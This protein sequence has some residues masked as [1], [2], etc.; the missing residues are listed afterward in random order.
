[1]TPDPQ[2]KKE[3]KMTGVERIAAERER[4]VSV[5]GWT[6]E[7]DDAHDGG[8]LA[9]AA[10]TY[11]LLAC[12]MLHDEYRPLQFERKQ[13]LRS[14]EGWPFDIDWWKPSTDPIRNLVKAGAL[15]AAE[16]DRLQRKVGSI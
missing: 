7:H 4:Q 10:S 8:V 2:R 5:E 11:T 14:R 9:A 1:M 6:P 16:I 15:I 12:D 3:S 13:D